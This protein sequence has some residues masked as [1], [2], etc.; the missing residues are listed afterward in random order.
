MPTWRGTATPVLVWW[1]P[2][3]V[4]EFV[5]QR[6]QGNPR[7]WK[8]GAALSRRPASRGGR[9][10]NVRSE[11]VGWARTPPSAA[12]CLLGHARCVVSEARHL[13]GHPVLMRD[14]INRRAPACRA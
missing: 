5:K 13:D 1:M 12:L 3:A 8:A 10:A 11:G 2:C 9:L 4:L 7:R 6:L 14:L